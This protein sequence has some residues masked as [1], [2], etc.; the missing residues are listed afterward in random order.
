M[1]Y[2]D[3]ELYRKVINQL[4]NFCHDLLADL[5]DFAIKNNY[6]KKWVFDKFNERLSKFKSAYIS[7]DAE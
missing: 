2:Y 5:S 6:N 1:L 7:G 3:E 4:D